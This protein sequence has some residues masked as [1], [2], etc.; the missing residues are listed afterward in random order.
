MTFDGSPDAARLLLAVA[1]DIG[2]YYVEIEGTAARFE[3]V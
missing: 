2:G 1:G 3:R